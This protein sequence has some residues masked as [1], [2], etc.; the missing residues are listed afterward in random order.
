MKIV[1]LSALLF[2]LSSQLFSVTVVT[3]TW[4]RKDEKI[5]LFEV[6][7]GKLKE[8]ASFILSPKK[9]F[10]F[11][12]QQ[13]VPGF[14]VI[15]T[16]P[17][18]TMDNYVFY[19]NPDDQL[20]DINVD[21]EV[22][23]SLPRKSTLPNKEIERWHN[24]ILPLKA[25]A[26]YFMKFNSDYK[27]FFPLLEQKLKEIEAYVPASTDDKAFEEAFEKYR[28]YDLMCDV[29]NFLNTPRSVHPTVKDFPAF[30]N[31]INLPE[32]TAEPAVLDF[33]YGMRL[34]D[35]VRR[36]SVRIQM[37]NASKEEAVKLND[38][39]ES[40]RRDLPQIP[41]ATVKGEVA[42]ETAR[43]IKTFEGLT[44]FN[45]EFGK[46]LVTESQKERMYQLLVDKADMTDGQEAFDFK[47][48]NA[49]DKEIALSDFRGKMVYIDVW[50]TWCGPCLKEIPHLKK[51]EADYKDKNIVFLG[52]SIDSQKDYTKWKEFLIKEELV[53]VQLFAGDKAGEIS[54]PYKITGIPRFILV[55][56]DGKIISADAPRPSSSEVK[57]LLDATVR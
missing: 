42:L 9:E 27:D 43:T 47:F 19:L 36:L 34:I 37:E 52:V 15:G 22:S 30:L 55:G 12:F 3:G 53:G 21:D 23:Y 13:S 20:L 18:S 54:K 39:Y 26:V 45:N 6:E 32:V 5:S 46:Y 11:A 48:K 38:S 10:S 17:Q 29:L 33:P 2:I 44:Q 16:S 50:A 51:L 57:L 1:L 41:D 25:R 56:K 4:N 35:F 8:V 24:L 49:N 28:R 14:Y 40:L 31:T 7:N